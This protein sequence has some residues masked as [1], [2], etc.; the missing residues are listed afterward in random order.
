MSDFRVRGAEE[1]RE[2][3]RAHAASLGIDESS[4]KISVEA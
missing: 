1:R 2:D 3:I 4:I